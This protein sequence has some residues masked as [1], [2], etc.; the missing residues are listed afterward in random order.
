MKPHHFVEWTYSYVFDGRL[1]GRASGQVAHLTYSRDHGAALHRHEIAMGAGDFPNDAVGAEQRE[2]AGD[3]A[4]PALALGAVG[5]GAQQRGP[6][7]PVSKT[8]ERPFAAGDHL[9]QRG[10]SGGPG[11]ERAVAAAVFDH[12]LAE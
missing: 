6:Y 3:T 11:I 8:V 12:A 5:G 4:G 9:H 1:A 2:R 7:I 10:V